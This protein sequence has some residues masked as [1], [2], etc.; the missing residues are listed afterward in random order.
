[1]IQKLLVPLDGSALAEAALPIAT[2]LADRTDATLIL[3]RA[4]Q[5]RSLLSDVAG[6]QYRV[7]GQA[8]DYL[9]QLTE[10]L[11]AQ[12]LKV[13]SGV[14][15]GGSPADWIL[16]ESEF[17][18]VDLVI[19]ATH[20]REGPDRWLHGSVAE[21]VVHRSKIPV[22][23]VRASETAS[24][25]AMPAEFPTP[26]PVVLV[27]LDGS[28]LAESALS[29]AAELQQA[30]AARLVLVAVVPQP[31]QLVAGEGGAITTYAGADHDR[32]EADATAYLAA[33]ADRVSASGG[34]AET[35]VRYGE[36]ASEI[37]A[38]AETYPATAVVMATHGR[39][40]V[41]RA[42]V[43]SVAGGVLRHTS[44]PVVLIHPCSS[45]AVD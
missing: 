12:G 40:G 19:M 33:A 41:L 24:Q 7:I 5:Y 37:S 2:T 28:D 14:P 9:A 18:H 8:E 17:R 13:E 27:P 25:A 20:G 10:R 34:A 42:M 15:F 35:V 1:M 11:Q 31:G 36:A 44:V 21:A 39:T 30:I 23:L 22:M 29:F 26:Q 43:G 38:A 3:L 32:L 45:A 16:E 4:A 6:D